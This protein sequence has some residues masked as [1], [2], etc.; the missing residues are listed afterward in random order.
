MTRPVFSASAHDI[1][2][3]SL[4]GGDISL[5][6]SGAAMMRGGEIHRDI[7]ADLPEGMESEVSVSLTVSGEHVDLRIGG[8]MD[9][10]DEAA[11]RILEIKSTSQSLEDIGEPRAEHLAQA[12]LYAEFA[13]VERGAERVTI[14]LLYVHSKTDERRSME[15]ALS[16]AE[17]KQRFEA[18]VWPYLRMLE[19][20][21]LHT[22]QRDEALAGLAFPYPEFRD[23]QRMMAVHGYTA[24]KEHKKL[25]LHAP[26]GTGKTIGVFY[27]ALKALSRGHID[28]IF[29]LTA[30]GTGR[31]QPLEELRRL[32]LPSCN[33]VVITAREKCCFREDQNCLECAYAK[34]Y[35]DRLGDLLFNMTSDGMLWDEAMIVAF[36]REHM[37]CPF[38]LSL[39]LAMFFGDI[40]LCDYNYFFAPGI[41][42]QRFFLTR[43][44]AGLLVD[45]AHQLESRARDMYSAELHRGEVK[46]FRRDF[47]KQYGRKN[48]LYK[49]I[50]ALLKT[51][52]AVEEG[53]HDKLPKGFRG[54]L[55]TL[56]ELLDLHIWEDPQ[57]HIIEFA[58]KMRACL[59]SARFWDENFGFLCE[60]GGH[61][62][63]LLLTPHAILQERMGRTNGCVLFSGTLTPLDAYARMLGGTEEDG[64]LQLPSPF[65]PENQRTRII[66]LDL[67]YNEREAQ[68]P[69]LAELMQSIA[70]EPGNY[71]FCFPSYGYMRSV[72]EYCEEIALSVT[73][74]RGAMSDAEREAFLALFEPNPESA[75]LFFIV[76]GGIFGESID[77]CGDRLQ[78]VVIIGLGLPQVGAYRNAISHGYSRTLGDGFYYAYVLPGL[79]RV[80][81]AAGRLIRS[82][83]DKGFVFLCDSRFAQPRYRALLPPHWIIEEG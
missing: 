1:V 33:T 45:E 64:K 19:L 67:R 16:A 68:I 35:Y 74:Q 40:I 24:F 7:Q 81:Q 22:R 54:A 52:E 53:L 77:L 28:R 8:R 55:K 62:T 10:Y 36:S 44:E 63:L 41:F 73:A 76:M 37:L 72:L 43:S 47:G 46:A 61:F 57:E 79:S 29:Y 69:R 14:E 80:V 9:G 39:D 5:S 20:R 31:L 2:D 15:V 83:D 51:V 70:E 11:Q 82:P 50:S 48:Q 21:W 56:C 13:R 78:G 26:T 71:L 18:L 12:I 60:K 49:A 65:P 59:V 38:E 32:N 23:A 6:F 58:G 75:R 17:V 4:M 30:R 27:G 3:F 34:G 66:P 25:F 42:L